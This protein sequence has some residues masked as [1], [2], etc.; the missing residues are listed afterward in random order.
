LLG[1][2]AAE[3]T[4]H[5]AVWLNKSVSFMLITGWI[6]VIASL[7]L[8]NI[9]IKEMEYIR[10]GQRT[11][12]ISIEALQ[13]NLEKIKNR[14]SHARLKQ[15]DKN[16]DYRESDEPAVIYNPAGNFIGKSDK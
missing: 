6:F 10:I 12:E 14:Q 2:I 3:T 11:L 8:G 1:K 13:M 7:V 15:I 4:T 16:T 5:P 9:A